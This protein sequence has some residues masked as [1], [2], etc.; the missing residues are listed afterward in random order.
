MGLYWGVLADPISKQLKDKGYNLP[1]DILKHFDRIKEAFNLLCY[2][3]LTTDR[4]HK[5]IRKKCNN[6]VTKEV[7]N[8]LWLKE[9]VCLNLSK[10]KK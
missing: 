5:A 7:K 9:Q 10:L 2:N 8:W 1:D 3:G 6:Y 4:Q